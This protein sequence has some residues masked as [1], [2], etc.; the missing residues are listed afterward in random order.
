MR[1]S[2]N[3][4]WRFAPVRFLLLLLLLSG[5][6]SVADGGVAATQR[7]LGEPE[8][9]P[10]ESEPERENEPEPEEEDSWGEAPANQWNDFNV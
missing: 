3:S 7:A 10:P 1:K 6:L 8:P 4:G 2:E 9:E 5:A